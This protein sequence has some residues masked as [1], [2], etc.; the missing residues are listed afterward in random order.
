MWVIQFQARCDRLRPDYSSLTAGDAAGRVES[1]LSVA[2][3][4]LCGYVEVV[5]V[6]VAPEPDSTV[7]AMMDEERQAPLRIVRAA[8]LMN[9]HDVH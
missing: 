1:A 7:D 3:L 5:A 8:A 4:E 2:L 9:E 6:S